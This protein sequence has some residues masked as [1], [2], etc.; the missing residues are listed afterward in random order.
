MWIKNLTVFV[1]EEAFPCSV[2]ELDE[3]LDQ[4]RC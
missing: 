4:N 1:G 2:A 3:I